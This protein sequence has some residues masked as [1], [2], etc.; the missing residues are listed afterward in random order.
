ME[1]YPDLTAAKVREAMVFSDVLLDRM[2]AQLR[3]LGLP[4]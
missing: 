3:K 2:T 4:K 1:S